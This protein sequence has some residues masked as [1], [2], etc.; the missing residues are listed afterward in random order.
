[1]FSSCTS[2]CGLVTWRSNNPHK[3]SSAPIG[4][5]AEED[6]DPI[7]WPPV[8]SPQPP[9][10]QK[11]ENMVQIRYISCVTLTSEI[12]TFKAVFIIKKNCKIRRKYVAGG[13][14]LAVEYWELRPPASCYCLFSS[15]MFF[16]Y[17]ITVSHCLNWTQQKPW[18]VMNKAVCRL[19][20]T[21]ATTHITVWMFC[22]SSLFSVNVYLYN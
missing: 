2:S 12:K 8:F 13:H 6:H 20:T 15:M 21:L 22:H 11:A 17:L 1:M 3:P 4:G 10:L 9:T 19:T 14:L 5:T 16:F 7:A 18:E